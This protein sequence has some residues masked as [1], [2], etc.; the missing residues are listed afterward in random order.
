MDVQQAQMAQQ[1]AQ[2]DGSTRAR[3]ARCAPPRERSM[4]VMTGLSLRSH[5]RIKRGARR[6]RR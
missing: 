4:V 5:S 2:G 3:R 1:Q 6:I